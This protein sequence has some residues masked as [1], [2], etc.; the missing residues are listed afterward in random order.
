MKKY[1]LTLPAVLAITLA[2]FGAAPAMEAN[3]AASTI[4]IRAGGG[5]PGY[6]VNMFLTDSVTVL[7]G[8]TVHWDFPWK[9]PH[10]V[11]FG[12]PA[13]DPTVNSG[14]GLST[15][16]NGTGY[17][18]SGF[19]GDEWPNAPGAPKAGTTF[20]VKFTKA[21]S[22]A[23]LCAI[24]PLMKGTVTVVDTGT[25]T[26][27]ADID[28]KANADYAAALAGLKSVA[29]GIAAKAVAVSAKADGTKQY[30][31]NIAGETDKGD[32]QQYS[33]PSVNV[34]QGDSVIF[35]SEVNTPHTVT[36]GPPPP[37]DPFAAKP[38]G[39]ADGKFPGGAASSAILGKS[40]AGQSWELTFTATGS[41]Q[42]LCILHFNQGMVGTVV[43]GAADAPAPTAPAPPKTGSGLDRG[44]APLGSW[45]FAGAAMA[46]VALAGAGVAYS[47]KR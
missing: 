18:S 22:Y 39:P 6:A 10:T 24:H 28:T 45:Y 25:A 26:K 44:D 36:F 41:F 33:P 35:K 2:V 32:V 1:L 3:A 46:L 23:F 21:G 16:Y 15:D 11:T 9:E 12:T 30:T 37:G 8:D 47:V 19:L 13:G 40:Y 38:T 29:S 20:D 17:I 43:V 42:Y 4:K 7:T 27:Q 14:V 5:E 31:V 34:K